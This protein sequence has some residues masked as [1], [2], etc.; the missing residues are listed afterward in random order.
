MF[1][2]LVGSNNPSTTNHNVSIQYHSYVFIVRTYAIL[3]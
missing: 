3:G 2:I 1:K